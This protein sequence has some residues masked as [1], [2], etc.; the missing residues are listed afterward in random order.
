MNNVKNEN[1]TMLQNYRALTEKHI[2][3]KCDDAVINGTIGEPKKFFDQIEIP[4]DIS[5][6]AGK[7]TSIS[8]LDFDEA[9]EVTCPC[10][11]RHEIIGFFNNSETYSDEVTLQVGHDDPSVRFDG[12]DHGMFLFSTENEAGAVIHCRVIYKGERENE[13]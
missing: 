1:N 12:I 13:K 11:S 9:N 2:I 5:I 7:S 6:P 3:A 8:I 4:M 10:I